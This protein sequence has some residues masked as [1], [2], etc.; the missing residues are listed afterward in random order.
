MEFLLLWIDDLDDALC[1]L[2]HLAPRIVGFLVAV[3]LFAATCFALIAV[4][5]LTLGIL[6]VVGS[7]SLIEIARRRFRSFAQRTER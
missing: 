7:A 4:P 2:R 6:A 3:A 5:Q 1:A